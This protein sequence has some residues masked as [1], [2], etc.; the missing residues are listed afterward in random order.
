MPVVIF[1]SNL[2]PRAFCWGRTIHFLY[3]CTGRCGDRDPHPRYHRRLPQGAQDPTA[4][5][6]SPDQQLGV[7]EAQRRDRQDAASCGALRGVRLPQPQDRPR[8]DLQARIRE[9][10]EG[11]VFFVLCVYPRSW[12]LLFLSLGLELNTCTARQVFATMR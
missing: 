8:A 11:T 10:E 3:F 7:R 1:Y 2:L 4:P 5:P 9:G 12:V 6:P